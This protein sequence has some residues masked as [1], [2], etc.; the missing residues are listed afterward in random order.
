[1]NLK[2]LINKHLTLIKY[3]AAAFSGH[4]L[5]FITAYVL[6]VGL[7]R[8]LIFSNT[9]GLVVGFLFTFLAS[10]I[11]FHKDYTLKG[12]LVYLG[13][14]LL[15]MVLDNL[16]IKLASAFFIKFFAKN[17]AFLISK[18]LSGIVP[19]AVSYILRKKIFKSASL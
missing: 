14:F 1:M 7:D 19:F 5:N 8:S 2:D 3:M 9:T 10:K 17:I 12:F 11:V 15:G 6:Y 4:V 18:V 13:T 16:I